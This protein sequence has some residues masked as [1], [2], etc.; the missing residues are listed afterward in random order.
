MHNLWVVETTTL[1]DHKEG[2]QI[3]ISESGLY[4]LIMSSKKPEAKA[5]KRWVTSVVLPSIRRTGSYSTQ[6]SEQGHVEDTNSH[7]SLDDRVV[8]ADAHNARVARLHAIKAA[9]EV[10]DLFGI[11][12]SETIEAQA[13]MAINEVLLPPGW[14]QKDM[15]DAAD[16][17]RRLGHTEA[18]IRRIGSEFGRALKTAKEHILGGA[19]SSS[20]ITNVQHYGL[21]NAPNSTH[22]YNSKEE[23]AFLNEVYTMFKTRPLYQRFAQELP[24]TTRIAEALQNTRGFAA[25]RPEI[26][27]ATKANRAK[28]TIS[29]R[30]IA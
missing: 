5:F 10:A 13:R 4:S 15:I 11:N 17:L 18:N 14:Q 27:S 24:M 7:L 3:L 20:S 22:M 28:K 19:P 6:G 2:A 26:D 12:V 21:V 25:S 16:Y 1:Q 23:A 9:K 8:E 30:N 29:K